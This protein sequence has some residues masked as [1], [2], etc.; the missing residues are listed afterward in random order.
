MFA[1]DYVGYSTSQLEGD[2]PSEAGCLRAI[3]AAWEYLTR[4]LG[5]SPGDIVLY[6]RSIGSGPTC[7]LASRPGCRDAIAGVVL[8]CPILSGGSVLLGPDNAKYVPRAL[9]S[10][11]ESTEAIFWFE[12]LSTYWI[13]N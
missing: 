12:H 9:A 7:D 8:Q 1:Y 11:P 13:L 4:D 5:V 10:S 6:G 3:T 2:A